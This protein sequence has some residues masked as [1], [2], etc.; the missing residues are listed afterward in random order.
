MKSNKFPKLQI[1][2]GDEIHVLDES[3]FN[4]SEETI[5]EDLMKQPS[6]FA[7]YAVHYAFALAE[8]EEAEADFN[9]SKEDMKSQL[10]IIEALLDDKFR[11]TLD[12]FT[13]PQIKNKIKISDEY[14][15]AKADCLSDKREKEQ[16]MIQKRRN[17]NALKAFKDASAQKK[18]ILISLASNLRAQLDTDVFLKH[19]HEKEAKNGGV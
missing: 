5:N 3:D 11:A 12:K 14:L 6:Q 16:A 19:K 18:E 10:E 1:R 15:K 8:S 17:A 7:F 13:E 9:N 4:C 2:I